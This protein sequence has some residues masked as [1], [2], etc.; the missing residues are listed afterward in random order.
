MGEDVI[1]TKKVWF[2]VVVV[3]SLILIIL[4]YF[5]EIKWILSPI[6]IDTKSIFIPLLI[7]GV[8]FYISL[9]LQI[10]LEKYKVPRWGSIAI[11][12]LLLIGLLWAAIMVIG[13]PVGKQV[14]NIVENAPAI[15]ESVNEIGRAHV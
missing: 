9:P 11:I 12:F 5:M 14:N 6:V 8:L 1:L 4:I 7:G 15:A 2:H 10:L 3:I 13:P